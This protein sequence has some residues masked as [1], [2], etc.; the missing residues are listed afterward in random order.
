M[1]HADF[2]YYPKNLEGAL[3]EELSYLFAATLPMDLL[4]KQSNLEA[5]NGS[6]SPG[7]TGS[8]PRE[9]APPL[10]NKGAL[11]RRAGCN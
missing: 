7:A 8:V 2:D 1:P 5:T 11:R 6:R 3:T 4:W 10:Q 9:W